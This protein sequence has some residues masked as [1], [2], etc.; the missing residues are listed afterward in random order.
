MVDYSHNGIALSTKKELTADFKTW[1][2]PRLFTKGK[3]LDMK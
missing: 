1:M 2:T 3:E